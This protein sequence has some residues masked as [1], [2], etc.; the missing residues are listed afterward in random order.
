MKSRSEELDD[1]SNNE[2]NDFDIK[3]IIG[4]VINYWY[5]FAIGI[6]VC[7]GLAFF[8]ARYATPSYKINGK[9][10]ID[11]QSNQGL[12]GKGSSSGSFD[13]SDILDI[14]SNAY[15][16]IDILTTRSLMTKVVN[17]L[18]LNVTIYRKGDIKYEELY[19][20]APFNIQYIS[21]KDSVK[22]VAFTVVFSKEEIN[23]TSKDYGEINTKLGTILRFD[24][25]E[26]IFTQKPNQIID[27]QKYK[28]TI[29]SINKKVDQLSKIFDVQLTDKK[30]S[31]LALSFE[32]PNPKKG[33]RLFFRL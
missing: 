23:I 1:F 24:N 27:G 22:D 28:I 19:D 26:L 11:D 7:F 10:T 3:K 16:E 30:S 6:V 18:Q 29:T 14:P 31:T 9:I 21:D 20:E 4:Q 12:G 25:F 13:F 2:N 33:W 15:N 17:E 5:L 32:Y 8:Y